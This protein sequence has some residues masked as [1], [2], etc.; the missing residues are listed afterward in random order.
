MTKGFTGEGTG[1][2]IFLFY[3]E[4]TRMNVSYEG[5]GYLAATF[6]A[7]S[8]VAG[9]V[10]KLG[11]LGM[12]EKCNEGDAFCGVVDAVENLRA[13]VQI[14]GFAQVSYTGTAPTRGYA[15]LSSNGK[16]GVKVD[17]NGKEYLVAAIN[18]D[19]AKITIKL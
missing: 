11:V 6:P 2:H 9:Q 7:G 15:K 10:C 17:S 8:C 5:V 19:E 13:A 12:C 3:K 18:T 16:G 14:E 1:G 4:E